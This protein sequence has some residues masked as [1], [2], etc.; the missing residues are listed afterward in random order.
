ML[1]GLRVYQVLVLRKTFLYF[2]AEV[3]IQNQKF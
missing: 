3:I 2:K 1:S